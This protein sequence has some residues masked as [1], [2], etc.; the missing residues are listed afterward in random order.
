MSVMPTC[1]SC[2]LMYTHSALV[3]CGRDMVSSPRNSCKAVDSTTAPKLL[4]R[5][6]FVCS[7]LWGGRW[8]SVGCRCGVGEAL[9]PP[10]HH[11]LFRC[12][13][14]CFWLFLLPFLGCRCLGGEVCFHLYLSSTEYMQ[15]EASSAFCCRGSG[16]VRTVTTLSIPSC[17]PLP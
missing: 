11:L 14:L 3:I 9:K 1:R 13:L 6:G 12:L 8:Q 4:L 7:G 16:K 10:V 2:P 5:L 15:K 17:L